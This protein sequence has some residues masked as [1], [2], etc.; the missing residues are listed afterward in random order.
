MNL[1]TWKDEGI[2]AAAVESKTERFN[3]YP[4]AKRWK[5]RP[6]KETIMINAAIM[7]LSYQPTNSPWLIDLD[8]QMA[9]E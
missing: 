7:D 5:V 1:V 4:E 8:L 3:L 6:G 2:G 9:L